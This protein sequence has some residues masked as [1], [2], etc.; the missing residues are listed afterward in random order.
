MLGKAVKLRHCPATV[1]ATPLRS[2]KIGPHDPTFSLGDSPA[3]LEMTTGSVPPKHFV[4]SFTMTNRLLRA[5]PSLRKL[6]ASNHAESRF[7]SLR[8]RNQQGR[9]CSW[10]VPGK[11]AEEGASQE[12]GPRRYTRLRSEGNEGAIMPVSAPPRAR[13]SCAR[14]L[15]LS[16]FCALAFAV[17]SQACDS[18]NRDRP[19]RRKSHRRQCI[20][21]QQQSGGCDHRFDCGWQ[22][23]A[24]DRRQGPIFSDCLRQP[25]FAK[26]QR[27]VSMP[28]SRQHRA[29]CSSRAGVGARVDRGH[30]HGNAHSAG[31]DQRRYHRDWA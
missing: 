23:S 8:H 3:R 27:P 4:P 16:S 5:V 10:L 24:D 26:S 17:P 13:L 25:T 21:D 12:T 30:S 22:L 29:Q 18:R 9:S 31:A 7:G 28:A 1:S 11:A 6:N 2:G 15:L 14:L 20:S 19:Y